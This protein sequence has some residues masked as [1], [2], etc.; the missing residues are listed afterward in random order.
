MRHAAHI[1]RVEL[2]QIFRSFYAFFSQ[3]NH[4]CFLC[5]DF[6]VKEVVNFIIGEFSRVGN[7]LMLLLKCTFSCS[8][9]YEFQ[10]VYAIAKLVLDDSRFGS[11]KLFEVM[12]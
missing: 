11:D 4:R 8:S 12:R 6:Y 9:D 1:L 3:L 7:F 10:R 5:A 2:N